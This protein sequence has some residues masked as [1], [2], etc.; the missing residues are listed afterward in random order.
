MSRVLDR[1]NVGTEAP[2]H[3]SVRFQKRVEKDIGGFTD[4]FAKQEFIKNLYENFFQKA[5]PLMKQKLGIVYTPVEIVDFLIHSVNDV[6]KEHFGKTLGSRNVHILDPFTGTGTFIARLLQ[7]GLISPK[8]I[9]HKYNN[10][11]HANEIVLLAYY[12][13]S[14]NIESAY[15]AVM[16]KAGMD[17]PRD[18]RVYNGICL[19]DTFDMYDRDDRLAY[20]M[21][22]NSAR[23]T[24]QKELPITVIVGNPPYSVGQKS[25]NDNNANMLYDTLNNRVGETYVQAADAGLK[26]NLFDSYVLAI[27]WASDRIKEAGVMAFVSNGGWIDTTSMAGLRKC[28]AEEFSC[29]YVFNLRGNINKFDKREGGN[30]FG[31]GCM[32]SV[33]LYL[34]VKNPKST[35]RGRIHYLDIGD[36]LSTEQKLSIIKSRGSVLSETDSADWEIVTPDKHS[37]W[38]NHRD[39]S[40]DDFMVLGDKSKNNSTA[41]F[42][43]YSLGVATNRD[44]WCINSSMVNLEKNIR[45]MICSYCREL[46]LLSKSGALDSSN[47][48]NRDPTEIKWSH[49]LENALKQKKNLKFDKGNIRL[50]LYR[51]FSKRWVYFGRDLNER[52]YQI[53]SL[54]PES[55]TKNRAFSVSGKG[56]ESDFSVLMTDATPELKTINKGQTFALWHRPKSVLQGGL[57]PDSGESESWKCSIT[58]YGLQHFRSHY[59]EQGITK[60]DVF[61]YV[62]GL[63]HSEQYRNRFRSNLLKQLP[64]IPPVKTLGA[65]QKFVAAGRVLG[66]LHVDFE[67]A[68]PYPV[69]IEWSKSARDL[70]PTKLYR[71]AKMKFAGSAQSKDR[72]RVIY[73]EHITMTGIPLEAYAYIVNG[74]PALK[75][76]MNRQCVKTDKDSEIVDDANLYAIETMGDPA[77]PLELFKRVITVSL[78]TMKIV[79]G[80]PD[81]DID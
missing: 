61:Y 21:P 65:F 35:V 67:K 79:K 16:E 25:Q 59:N 7:S 45:Q 12:V 5:G 32:T 15:A 27:R 23:R 41:V 13:A 33:A 14:I 56:S 11:I 37:D 63:L 52:V 64:R 58:D 81:L 43:Q 44:A 62:Y 60:E 46:D 2:T 48:I 6:L 1:L 17:I 68:K 42:S 20:Y 26:R 50:S 74:H 73:N 39:D 51:P 75:W 29:L 40:F 53:P 28:L 47:E 49:N 66:D 36:A 71:V 54:F 77:Y 80:L 69:S 10:E 70:A 22:D 72:T 8:E 9:R 78:E 18:E 4:A 38:V 57:L 55:G 31:G 34:F 76:V 24:R 30:V 3:D 19:T